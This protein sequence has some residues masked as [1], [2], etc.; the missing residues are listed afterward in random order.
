LSVAASGTN[1]AIT[2]TRA[3]DGAFFSTNTFFL[4]NTETERAV[5]VSEVVARTNAPISIAPI[6]KD[7]VIGDT[8]FNDYTTY[9]AVQVLSATSAPVIDLTFSLAKNDLTLVVSGL[10]ADRR[11]ALQRSTNLIDWGT[12]DTIS[13]ETTYTA[14]RSPTF[15]GAFYRVQLSPD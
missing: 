9:A 10:E 11:Y 3:A 2:T 7:F 14:L 4:Y 13:G 8:L 6:G 5:S 15:S 12:I 1:I